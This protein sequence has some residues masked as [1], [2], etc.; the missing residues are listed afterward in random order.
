[1]P[2]PLDDLRR[3]SGRFEAQLFTDELFHARVQMRMRA[4]GAADLSHPDPLPHL[5]EPLTRARKFVEHRRQLQT[6]SNRFRMDSVAATN[7]R[8]KFV[9][10]RPASD[11]LAQLL[12]IIQQ[13]RAG[14]IHLHGQ[15]RVQQVRRGQPLVDPA[16]GR[17]DPRSDILEKAITS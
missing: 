17:A 4:D 15:R 3:Q 16:R 10:D 8:G 9:L 5:P 14:R 1:M 2:V 11:R 13:D 12:Q 6:K 7:H